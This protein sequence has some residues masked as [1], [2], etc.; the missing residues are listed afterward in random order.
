D[1]Q[2][3]LSAVPQ[4]SRF[5]AGAARALGRSRPVVDEGRRAAAV[6]GSAIEGRNARAA[7]TRGKW[8]LRRH[9]WSDVYR[10]QNDALPV[11]LRTGLLRD[12]HTDDQPA[13]HYATVR[14]QP[15]KRSDLSKLRTEGRPRRERHRRDP[16]ARIDG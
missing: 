9:S 5:R 3:P 13:R 11:R 8:T 14:G 16:A 10:P 2:R 1:L 12:R 4:S 7:T 15:R 6:T